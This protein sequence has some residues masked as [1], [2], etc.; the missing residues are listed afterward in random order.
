MFALLG[1]AERIHFKFYLSS[2]NKTPSQ[3]VIVVLPKRNKFASEKKE[4]VKRYIFIIFIVL[5]LSAQGAAVRIFGNAKDYAGSE[6]I[7]YKYSDRITFIKE[8][9]FTLNIDT[10]G[11]FDTSADFED[12]T[13]VFGEF[14]VYHA[15]FYAEPGESY[16]LILPER[17]ERSEGD[18]FNPYYTPEEIQIG[19]KNLTKTDLNYLIIDFDYYYFRY[20]DIKYLE[21]YGNG[22]SSDVDTF[23][24]NINAKYA[25]ITNTYFNDY[26]KYRIAA[27]K[28]I[29]TQKKF[30]SALA[31]SYFTKNPVL[32][33]NPAYM[34]LFNNIYQNYFDKYLTS[35]N[36]ALL[37]AV[38]NYGHS[39]SR[40]KKL[41]N[42]HLEFKTPQFRELVILKGLND[43]FSSNNM[44]WLP[45]LLTLDSVH[46]STVYPVHKIIAQ[47]IA[48]NILSLAK[49]TVAPPFELPDTSGEIRKL[50]DYRGK[51]V[52]LQY[53]NTRSYTSQMEFPLVKNLYDRYKGVCIFVTILTDEDREAAKQYIKE[54]GLAWN[55][56]FTEIN[57]PVISTYK[58]AAYPTYYL[59]NTFGNLL[60]SPAPAPSE[61]FETGFFKIVGDEVEKK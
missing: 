19:I 28:N 43:S 9:V 15:Y 17:D 8:Q 18:L 36:G 56:L 16:E 33:D 12:I 42:Q 27:L 31:Y 14:G 32:Y 3:T 58:V 47:N 48:D 22:L 39:I 34:D 6:L 1:S 46:L 5:A 37:Y 13:Y 40:L 54:N 38:I 35:P 10:A 20:L 59:I 49:G 26:K 29:A 4:F 60:M 11:N 61:N 52:Y 25:D 41:L 45:L 30:E 55:F 50:N 7:F 24:N 23:I 57:S 51:Y 53:A 44:A 21:V 2:E